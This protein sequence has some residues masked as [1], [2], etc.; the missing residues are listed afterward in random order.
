MTDVASAAGTAEK[1]IEDAMKVEPMIA[2]GVGMLVPGAAPI[3]AIVQPAVAM[4][5][6]F[7][8]KALEALAANKGGDAFAAFV[9]LLQHLTPGLPNSSILSPPST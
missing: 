7:V 3:V 1:V 5:A 9:E 2:T 8:E 6:P 4:A